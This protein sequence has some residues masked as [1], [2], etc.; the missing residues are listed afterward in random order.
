MFKKR[1]AKIQKK[2]DGQTVE[3]FHETSLQKNKKGDC[4]SRLLLWRDRELNSRPPGY[5]SDALT[6]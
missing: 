1:R 6:N 2:M 4:N 3:T 5:E